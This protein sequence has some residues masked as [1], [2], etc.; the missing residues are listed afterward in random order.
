MLWMILFFAAFAVPLTKS[1]VSL[2][3]AK[4][5]A[6]QYTRALEFDYITWT[7]DATGIKAGMTGIAPSQRLTAAQQHQLVIRYFEL[8]SE[9]DF[10]KYSVQLI[11]SNP[12][13]EN[14]EIEAREELAKQEELQDAI[15]RLDPLVEDILQRQVANTL[16]TMGI[17]RLGEAIPPV[18]YHTSA[19]P[20]SLIT[21]PRDR[22]EQDVNLSLMADLT[23]EQTNT[24]E[25]QVEQS[26]GESA[27]VVGTGGI[28]VY[29]TMIM[30]TADLKWVI[31]T[32][33]HEWTHNYLTL[34]LLGLNY[35][36]SPEL[37][38]MNETA[39]A[40]AGNEIGEEVIKTYYPELVSNGNNAVKLAAPAEED[41]FNFQAEM[42]ITRVT[43]DKL[44][45]LGKVNEAE[46]YM[47]ERR[48]V[49]V[50]HGYLI[51][52]IN[53]AYFAFYGAYAD[54][55][56]GAAGEDPVGGAV[57]T[58]WANS[59]S[60]AVFLRTMGKMNSYNDLQLAIQDFY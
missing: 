24:L 48:Q 25:E 49:F 12:E 34:R 9:L 56:V 36:T 1:N 27:L 47:E 3:S 15:R 51:R 14:P 45:A 4:D 8:V 35:D 57:R 19:T 31:N 11:Y 2:I 41:G 43:V 26:T 53:Q 29:P 28:G 59:E 33:A 21:S 6:Q 58:L 13:V 40:I 44:L 7:L 54:S 55:P 5:K 32:I 20:K 46:A 50:A 30:R 42:H 60:L 39:A 52:K 16:N 10:V 17:I 38:T 23:L 22:I 37:R 18:L